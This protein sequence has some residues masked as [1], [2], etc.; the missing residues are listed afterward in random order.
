[1]VHPNQRASP[2]ILNLGRRA[3]NARWYEAHREQVLARTKRY[4]EENR[5]RINQER[6]KRH[7]LQKRK[8][9]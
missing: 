9:E 1:L 7:R 5:E 6:K 2:N 4:Y 3:D 8:A